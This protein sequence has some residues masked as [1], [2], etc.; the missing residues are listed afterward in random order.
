MS[1]DGTVVSSS[2]DRTG[3]YRTVDLET[4]C[5]RTR[6]SRLSALP[7]VCAR[8]TRNCSSLDENHD[9]ELPI[10]CPERN[11]QELSALF[12]FI[13]VGNNQVRSDSVL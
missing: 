6:M 10:G 11:S 13:N 5:N 4:Q 2:L 8:K 12:V 1:P 7:V 9:L 3:T